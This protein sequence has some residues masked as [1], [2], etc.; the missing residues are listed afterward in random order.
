VPQNEFGEQAPHSGEAYG[1]VCIKKEYAEYLATTLTDTLEKDQEYLVECYISR[2]EKSKSSVDEFG[3]LFTDKIKWNLDMRGI[4]QKPGVDFV[5]KNGFKEKKDW[6]KLSGIYRAE[7]F[8]TVIIIGYFN[9]D[10]PKGHR[11]FCHYYIDD[12]SVSPVKR[13]Q[14]SS[15]VSRTTSAGQKRNPLPDFSPQYGETFTLENILFETNRSELLP[16]SY[17]DLDKVI[18]YLSNRFNTSIEIRGHTDNTGNEDQ[19]KNLSE[20]R[21]KAVADYLILKGI[22]RARINY[23]GHGSSKPIANNNTEEGRLRNRRVEF[24]INKK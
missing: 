7:G 24:T 2:A 1:G 10:N 18:Q 13:E 5:K 14:D 4:S 15:A 6:I 3:V 8:E 19:N 11:H 23:S 9:Y 17:P 22:D 16:Q 12:V 21:A 20:A